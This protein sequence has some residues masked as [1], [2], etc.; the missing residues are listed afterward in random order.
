MPLGEPTLPAGSG[1]DGSLK[2]FFVYRPDRFHI[3]AYGVLWFWSLGFIPRGQHIVSFALFEQ[4]A[5]RIGVI[6]HAEI[7][8]ETVSRA[9]EDEAAFVLMLVVPVGLIA[10]DE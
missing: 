3:G 2:V 4:I 6:H 10:Q 8:G 1:I 5:Y 9:F 7:E